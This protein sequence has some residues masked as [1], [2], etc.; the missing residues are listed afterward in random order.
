MKKFYSLLF[1]LISLSTVF[2]S[3]A[4][5]P[6]TG[7]VSSRSN[8]TS[9]Y[10]YTNNGALNSSFNATS[11]NYS[12]GTAT[13]AQNNALRLNAITIGTEQYQ[14]L[15]NAL[16]EVKIRRVNNTVVSGKRS[17]VWV[18]KKAN[19]AANAVAV[20]NAYN[21]NMEMVFDG[22]NLNQGTD[23]LFA[24]QGDGNGNNN[25]IERLDVVFRGG[26]STSVNTKTGFTLF[27]RGDDNAHD[28]FVIAAITAIDINGNATAYGNPVRVASNQYGNIANSTI[29]YYVMRRD[30]V[31]ESNLRMSTSGTQKIGGVFVSFSAL[32]VNNAQQIYGYSIFAYDLPTNATAANLV[33]YNNSTYFPKTT[34]SATQE[35]GIDLIAVTGVMTA[36]NNVILPPVAE[37]I[38]MPVMYNNGGIKSILPLIANASVGSIAGYTI[39]SIPTA[40]QGILYVCNGSNC[41]PVTAGQVLT[42]AQINQ[43]S[44]TPNTSFTGTVLFYYSAFDTY[45]QTSN[46]ATYM[47]P[48]TAVAPGPLPIKLNV[49]TGKIQ[50]KK[51]ILNWQTEQ[52]INASHFELQRSKDGNNFETIATPTAN[53]NSSTISNYQETDDLF[54]YTATT[55][56]Y[57]LKMVDIDGSAKFSAI[58][59]LKL[60]AAQPT[61]TLS[62]FPNPFKGQLNATY[63]SE[64][65]GT[66]QMMIKAMDGKT[67]QSS[68]VL[69]RKGINTIA[70][71]SVNQL[72]AGTYCLTIVGN[73]QITTLKLV[74]Q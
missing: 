5:T 19:A 21:D 15:Q 73:N 7:V 17:L 44:F 34:G 6:I 10:S 56:Y 58:V 46:V 37:N 36:I 74:K 18:E 11:H 59:V 50:D 25:N 35:G 49:F 67:I 12:F 63:I 38:V 43:L 26:V 53:G 9:G 47:I 41:T 57:R 40:A 20:V 23:N 51:A 69:V 13:T 3:N 68:S 16:S 72:T 61:Q 48:V 4:Q 60:N 30:S 71:Q 1:V 62:A 8:A 33:N 66:V 2:S 27:E 65:E 64:K 28:P 14:Y 31:T 22:N 39:H 42:P 24:N 32:G 70:V 52:E 55:V 45:A 54:F 29:D